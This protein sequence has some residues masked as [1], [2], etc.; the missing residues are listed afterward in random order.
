MSPGRKAEPEMAFSTIGIST[1]SRTLRPASMIAWASPRTLAA[2]PMSF[3]I[4]SM[5]ADGLM[6]RPPVSKV[7]PLPTRVILGSPARPQVRSSRRGAW[8]LAR[9]T[10]WIIGKFCFSSSSPTIALTLHLVA[11]G[12]GADF[13]VEGIGAEI[14]WRCV[15]QVARQKGAGGET[16]DFGR[17]GA[18][19][20]RQV[21]PRRGLPGSDRSGRFQGESP[22]RRRSDRK[23]RPPADSGPARVRPMR[24]H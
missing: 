17:I 15:D 1:R 14:V 18:F 10:A 23:A 7:T 2:P 12:E 16:L 11:R 5:P 3:F 20:H 13:L 24:G 9:P 6:S 19:G 8:A 21:R 22:A 4:S